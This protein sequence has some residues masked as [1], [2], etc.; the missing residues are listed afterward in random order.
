VSEQWENIKLKDI[1]KI[2][3]GKSPSSIRV[4]SSDYPIYGT[5]GQVGY[6]KS[7]LFKAPLILIG[8]KGTIDKPFYID[9]DCWI[10]DTAYG[11]SVDNKSIDLKWLYYFLSNFD[12]AKLNEATGVPSLNRENLYNIKMPLPPR[13]EQQKIVTILSTVDEAI[14]KTKAIIE[15]TEKVKKGIIQQILTKGIGHTKFKKA[16]IGEIPE[17]WKVASIEEIFQEF[18]ET[19]S[20]TETYP[21]FSLT[22]E[23][24]LTPKT[25]RYERGFLL[26]DRDNNQYRIVKPNNILFNPMNLR[27]GAIAISKE[28]VPVCVSAYYNVLKLKDK[29]CIASY[30][31]YLFSSSL[32]IGLYE[33]IA[34]GSLIEKKRVH[35]SQFLKLKIPVP[36]KEEQEKIAR[37]ISSIEEKLGKEREKYSGLLKIKQGLMQS[38]LTGKVRVKVDEAEVTQV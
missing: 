4:D 24:G 11:L 34:T 37:V 26:K 28:N 18:R 21:L 9:K 30:Y 17:K 2:E 20:D 13:K 32:Y 1:S 12:L 19:T 38:L 15:Q 25:D 35:L 36:S 29:E 16:E 3:Y 22:I 6:A 27:F 31:N 10:I 23:H 33:R 8:R 5:S 14:E 7:S